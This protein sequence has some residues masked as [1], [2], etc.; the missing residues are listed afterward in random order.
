M[1]FVHM[2]IQ[3][4]WPK[5][6]SPCGML[7]L[8]QNEAMLARVTF[9]PTFIYQQTEY[10]RYMKVPQQRV[11]LHFRTTSKLYHGSVIF[12]TSVTSYVYSVPTELCEWRVTQHCL[13]GIIFL[14][15][16]PQ[17]SFSQCF[18]QGSCMMYSPEFWSSA[19]DS[20]NVT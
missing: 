11:L 6:E 10:I 19:R 18:F 20:K 14:A 3:Y 12:V 2:S 13:W 15:D 7:D 8:Q 4:Q 17:A 5:P 1:A 9:H 16:P